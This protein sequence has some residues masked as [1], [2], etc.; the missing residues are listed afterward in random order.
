[1]FFFLNLIEKRYCIKSYK[2]HILIRFGFSSYAFRFSKGPTIWLFKEGAM[3]SPE[4]ELFSQE[5]KFRIYF[6]MKNQ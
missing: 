1:M 3:F 2:H 4:H 6:D 5:T